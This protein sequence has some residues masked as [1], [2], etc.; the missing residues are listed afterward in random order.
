MRLTSVQVQRMT[1]N[2]RHGRSFAWKIVPI[3]VFVPEGMAACFRDEDDNATIG[4]ILCLQKNAA[5]TSWDIVGEISVI[6]PLF[7]G[8]SGRGES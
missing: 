7:C 5:I 1:G 2:F 3:Q 6:R 8:L 4:V